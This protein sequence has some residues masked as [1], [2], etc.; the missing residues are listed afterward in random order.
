M[1]VI[2]RF[3][4]SC[5]Q[6]CYHLCQKNLGG[7]DKRTFMSECAKYARLFQSHSRGYAVRE[8]QS[9]LYAFVHH[10]IIII[11]DTLKMSETPCEPTVLTVVK[12]DLDRMKLFFQ[13]YRMLGV[14][15]FVIIDNGSTDGTLEWVSQQQDTRCYRV[16]TKFQTES[17]VG[18]IE[19]VLSLTGY[20]RWYVVVD[21]DE[22][23][24]YVGSERNNLMSLLL[25]A[26][27]NGY[28]H[29]NGYLLDMY[30]DKPLF[31][32]DCK[33]SDIVS[34]FRYFDVSSYFLRDIHSPIIDTEINSQRG[35]PR[36]RL[37]KNKDISLNKQSVFY[38][39]T[40]TLY[41][42]PHYLWPYQGCKENP[43]CFVLRHYKFLKRDL[44]EFERR[45]EAKCF[46]NGS[47][48]YRGYIDA[49]HD[50][51]GICMKCN[52]SKEYISSHSLSTLPFLE[53]LF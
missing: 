44:C 32:E 5:S 27:N 19:K 9:Q 2:S 50:N 20:N 43:Q 23:L 3:V 35:G 39:D 42:N 40:D 4:V 15:Q 41:C 46:W 28:K 24:D 51:L 36:A 47:I 1:R 12:D 38:F 49:Y 53:S 33:Y 22:L 13:H 16:S 48:E 18:W 52:E 8:L 6:I 7:M 29:L 34:R 37:F 10:R 14:R 45:V 25:I 31:T 21:S 30:S 17:K 11:S 26:Q